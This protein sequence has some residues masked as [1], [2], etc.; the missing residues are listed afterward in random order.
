M[1]QLQQLHR[2][3]DVGEPA[4]AE[5]GVRVRSAPRGS[6]SASTRAL[7]RRISV[8]VAGVEALGRV[9]DRVDHLD[10]AAPEVGVA[11]DGRA[12]SSACASHACDQRA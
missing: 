3:L 6:R 12:R 7:I 4:Q 9:A 5:L 8:T 1:L 11:R 2:P 10:E